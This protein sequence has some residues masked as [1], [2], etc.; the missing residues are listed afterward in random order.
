MIATF[1]TR[2]DHA[3]LDDCGQCFSSI[4]SLHMFGHPRLVHRLVPNLDYQV[5]EHVL[6]FVIMKKE[7]E[8]N[9]AVLVFLQKQ[10]LLRNRS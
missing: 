4:A 6:H 2:L 7:R 8:F 5:W 9:D 1:S 3:E 10:H